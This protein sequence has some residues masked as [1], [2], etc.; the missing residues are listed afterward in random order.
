MY[1]HKLMFEDKTIHI[2]AYPT[3][4]ILAEK[5]HATF[6]FGKDNSRMKDFYDLYMIPK[7]ERIDEKNLYKSVQGT[8]KE[9]NNQSVSLIP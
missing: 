1:E 8:F 3:E 2:P 6:S 9:R 4:Q 7:L 5:L